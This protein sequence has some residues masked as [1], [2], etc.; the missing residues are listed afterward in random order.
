MYANARTWIRGGSA[1]IF[2]AMISCAVLLTGCVVTPAPGADK[3]KVT[4]EPAD[5]SACKAVGNVHVPRDPNGNPQ[6]VNVD[7]EFRNLVI[8]LDGN[9]GLITAGSASAP[10][11]GIAYRCP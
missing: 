10:T 9:V 4:K 8:G 11:E 3:V 1:R 2:P 5:V 7:V 6:F